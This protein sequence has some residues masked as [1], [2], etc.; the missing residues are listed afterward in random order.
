M[1]RGTT[2]AGALPLQ[3][4]VAV[5]TGVS[6]RVGIGFTVASRLAALGA[7]LFVYS[8]APFDAEQPWG[9]DAEG[10]GPLLAALQ[11]AGN[12]VKHLEADFSDPDAPDRV[13][14]ALYTPSGM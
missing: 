9:A 3:G 2:Q 12:R 1:T 7:D 6:R 4:R 10:I 14:T 13:M 8:F 11:S 5:V